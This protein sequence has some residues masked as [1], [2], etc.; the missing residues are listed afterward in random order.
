MNHRVPFWAQPPN[1]RKNISSAWHLGSSSS[2]GT[3]FCAK[4]FFGTSRADF[5]VFHALGVSRFPPPRPAWWV[6]LLTR[7]NPRI[8]GRPLCPPFW[9]NPRRST[10]NAVW[11]RKRGTPRWKPGKWQLSHVP[12]VTMV[13]ISMVGAGSSYRRFLFF[14]DSL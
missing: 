5:V 11:V 12:H 4:K 8:P 9:G 3:D 6:V 7:E 13:I 2:C 1:P 10:P 14:F